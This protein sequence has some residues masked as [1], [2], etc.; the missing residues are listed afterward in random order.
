MA[1]AA[2][3]RRIAV[4]LQVNLFM[5]ILAQ[6]MGCLLEAVDFRVADFQRMTVFAFINNHYFILGVMTGCAAE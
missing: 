5:T 4:P 1:A 6:F 3:N 2:F